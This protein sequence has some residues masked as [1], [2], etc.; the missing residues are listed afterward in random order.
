MVQFK[1]YIFGIIFILLISI[2]TV[3]FAGQYSIEP[4]GFSATYN[5]DISTAESIGEK[6][7]GYIVNIAAISSVVIIAFLGLKFM[8]GSVEQ[9]AEYKKSFMPLIVGMFVVLSSSM[10]VGFLVDGFQTNTVTA[11][12][13]VHSPQGTGVDLGDCSAGIICSTCKKPGHIWDEY[14]HGQFEC[15]YCREQYTYEE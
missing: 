12:C 6:I 1:I 11:T 13:L 3:S 4:G 8:V 15:I 9:R 10:L 7:L 14:T 2:T 5:T